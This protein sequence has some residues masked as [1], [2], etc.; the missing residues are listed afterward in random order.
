MFL[1]FE[2][3][4]NVSYRSDNI[5]YISASLKKTFSNIFSRKRSNLK[6][7]YKKQIFLK[8][9]SAEEQNKEEEEH[10]LKL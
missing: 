5:D 7:P 8:L 4:F 3:A 9:I 6:V 1:P 10:S 2:D